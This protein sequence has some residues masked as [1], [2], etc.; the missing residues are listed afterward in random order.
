MGALFL[1]GRA[2]LF[3]ASKPGE[4]GGEVVEDARVAAADQVL[5]ARL[6]TVMEAGGWR[7]EGMT[8]GGLARELGTPEHQLRRL[9][10]RRLGHRNFADFVNGYR[11]AAAKARLADPAE[12]RTTIAVIAFDLGFGSLSPFNRAFRASTG[13]TPTAWRQEALHARAARVKAD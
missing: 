2:S 6:A 7:N 1:H 11:V 13:S 8:I 10:N 5:L 12:A 3:A 9:I 4:A